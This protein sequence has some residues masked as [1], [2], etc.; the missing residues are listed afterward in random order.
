MTSSSENGKDGSCTLYASL[1]ER[2]APGQMFILNLAVS[3][4]EGK[5]KMYCPLSVINS[6]VHLYFGIVEENIKSSGILG[7]IQ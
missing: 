3:S 4:T 6:P 1:G 2:A 7:A 5:T